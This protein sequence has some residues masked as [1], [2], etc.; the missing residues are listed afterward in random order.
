MARRILIVEDE[1]ELLELVKIRL[2]SNG[3]EVISAAN[4]KDG[5]EKAYREKPDLMLLDLMLPVIDGHWVCNLLKHD[6][7]SKEIPI[8]IV[9]AKSDEA[10]MKLAKDCGANDYVVKPFE[11]EALLSK[12]SGL[13]K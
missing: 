5:L 7:R 11:M 4:G 13:L 2:E 9:S 6:K 10:N 12:I 3:Y 1:S 8:I